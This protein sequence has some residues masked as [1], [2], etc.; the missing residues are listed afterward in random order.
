MSE[1]NSNLQSCVCNGFHVHSCQFAVVFVEES[2]AG[3][4]DYIAFGVARLC[5]VDA[6]SQRGDE[7][8]VGLGSFKSAERVSSLQ[9]EETKRGPLA[10][11]SPDDSI[12]REEIIAGVDAALESGSNAYYLEVSVLVAEIHV[13][14]ER[15]HIVSRHVDG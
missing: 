11:R 2:A 8:S 5:Q 4:N 12:D 7:V 14:V 9:V 13:K 1:I 6:A 15:R 10:E 3:R